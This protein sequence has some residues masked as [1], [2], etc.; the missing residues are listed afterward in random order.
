MLALLGAF[1]FCLGACPG[2]RQGSAPSFTVAHPA[3]SHLDEHPS[4]TDGPARI[5]PERLTGFG[6]ADAIQPGSGYLRR[7]YSLGDKR[8]EITVARMGGEPGA[9]EKW[10]AGSQGYPQATLALPPSEANGF[11]T[12]ASDKPDA[13]CDLHIQLRQGF[14]VEMMGNGRVPRAD[15]EQMGK[16]FP[17]AAL[18][19]PGVSIP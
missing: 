15:L 14:H 18:L 17:L 6:A 9:Y 13:A 1:G 3:S 4:T 5:L 10:L 16:G 12:C 19:A 7:S 11:F 8:V 2:E